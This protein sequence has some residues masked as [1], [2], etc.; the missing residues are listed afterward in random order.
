MKPIIN[1]LV[2][3]IV[4]VIENFKFGSLVIP[5]ILTLGMLI[6]ACLDDMSDE[7][8]VKSIKKLL[9]CG[10]CSFTV[11]MILPS[12]ETCYKMIVA[13]QVTGKNIQ[14]AEDA[15]KDSVD[16]IFEKINKD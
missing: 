13:S 2:F 1:P 15:I 8:F 7:E 3:Y 12:K 6:V 5:L 16:Y 14:K 4:N 11:W 10:L 9:I